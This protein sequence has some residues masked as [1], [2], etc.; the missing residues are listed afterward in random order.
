MLGKKEIKKYFG[1]ATGLNVL[2]VGDVMIDSY[3][4]GTVDRISP[5]APVP[6]VTVNRRASLLGG[7]LW[8]EPG[9]EVGASFVLEV[10]VEWRA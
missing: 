9:R 5:E 1:D 10:P 2:I 4:W 3:I 7:A 8:S 6:I